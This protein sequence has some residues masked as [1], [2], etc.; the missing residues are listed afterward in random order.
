MDEETRG[1]NVLGGELE[2]CCFDPVTG[3]YRDGT[4]RTGAGDVGVHAVCAVMTEEFLAFSSAVGND[5]STPRPE[6]GF[7]GLVPGDRWCVCAPRWQEALEAD[8][9]PPVV[10]AATHAAALEF[11]SLA[12]LRAHGV[13]AVA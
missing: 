12:D 13:D 9:A 1:Q 7:R 10:L 6:W 8:E 5:L 2:P 4:C 11:C 3:F